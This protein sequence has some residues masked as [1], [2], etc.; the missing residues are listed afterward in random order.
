MGGI[1]MTTK[2]AIEKYISY[3]Q[4][5]GEQ[6]KTDGAILRSFCRNV[7]EDV[8]FASLA[9]E[10]ILAFIYKDYD[11]KTSICYKRYATLR[12]F[13]AWAKSRSYV[14]TNPLPS[15]NLKYV[16]P[17]KPC[18]YTDEELQQIFETT[19]VY[20]KHRSIIYPEMVYYTLLFT[21]VMGLRI[22]E[23]LKIKI[24][25]IDINQSYIRIR[26]TKFHKSRLVTFNAAVKSKI[27]EC[28]TWRKFVNMPND[29]EDY[30]LLNRM[31][32]P[33]Q[34]K[35]MDNIFMRIRQK[36]GI[37]RE[38]DNKHQPHIH[39]LRHTFAVNRVTKWYKEG[40]DVQALLPILSTYMGHTKLEHTAVYI[41]MTDELLAE[42]NRLFEDFTNK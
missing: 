20:Q 19:L 23:T 11:K 27:I 37:K 14:N 28:L 30:L 2:D 31:N 29:N 17:Q 4:S 33:L 8:G 12:G 36:A 9:T 16:R 39:T 35:S 21:Y 10:T 6:F 22:N 5:L 3:R 26:Q 13:F 1:I 42:A 38:T 18:I 15:L 40:K 41:I 25:D 34:I 32:Q 24:G 7:G